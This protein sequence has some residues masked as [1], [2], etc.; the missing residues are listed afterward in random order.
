M[1]P[2]RDHLQF[3]DEMAK[4]ISDRRKNVKKGNL[5]N[6]GSFEEQH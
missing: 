2:L 3:V 4:D 1:V 5:T 6:H